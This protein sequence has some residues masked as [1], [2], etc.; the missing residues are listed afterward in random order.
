MYCFLQKLKL[1]LYF[2]QYSIYNHTLIKS[3]YLY[4]IIYQQFLLKFNFFLKNVKMT[5][6][7][8]FKFFLLFFLYIRI[9]IYKRKKT[10]MDKNFIL[11]ICYIYLYIFLYEKLLLNTIFDSYIWFLLANDKFTIFTIYRHIG[12]SN[13]LDSYDNI[14][15]PPTWADISGS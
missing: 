4:V 10:Y 6:L 8:I 15:L 5:F 3:L 13:S 1:E 9:E 2:T 12:F 7:I 11:L 14:W